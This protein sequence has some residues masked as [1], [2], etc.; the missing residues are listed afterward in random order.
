MPPKKPQNA[1]NKTNKRKGK[2]GKNRMA[3][4]VAS[5]VQR[6]NQKVNTAVKKE[7]QSKKQNKKLVSKIMRD[8]ASVQHTGSRGVGY[9][10]FKGLSETEAEKIKG[11]NL[12]REV[13]GLLGQFM[14]PYT[15][16]LIRVRTFVSGT[17]A[18]PTAITKNFVTFRYSLTDVLNKVKV[19]GVSTKQ[20]VIRVPAGT[21]KPLYPGLNVTNFGISVV[22]FYDPYVLG[23]LPYPNVSNVDLTDFSSKF[24]FGPL[25]S[26]NSSYSPD[27]FN[28]IP[29][30]GT[31]PSY[32]FPSSTSDSLISLNPSML[33]PAASTYGSPAQVEQPVSTFDQFQWF[34]IDAYPAAPDAGT[35]ITA[36]LVPTG[37]LAVNSI[38]LILIP[39]L[40]YDASDQ[41]Q[42]ASSAF[43]AVASGAQS[44]TSIDP[45]SSGWYRLQLRSLGANVGP[46]SSLKIRVDIN[47]KTSFVTKFVLNNSLT[48]TGVD[49]ISSMSAS[50]I[51]QVQLNGSSLLISNISMEGAKGGVVYAGV[52]HG[53]KTA[54][55]ALSRTADLMLDNTALVFQTPWSDGVYGFIKPTKPMTMR[56]FSSIVPKDTTTAFHSYV[57]EIDPEKNSTLAGMNSYYISPVIS[58]DQTVFSCSAN[59]SF[60]VAIEFQ[61]D[62]QLF[63]LAPPRVNNDAAVDAL[64]AMAL[65]THPFSSNPIHWKEMWAKLRSA[66]SYVFSETAPYALKATKAILP[67]LGPLGGVAAAGL[68][69]LG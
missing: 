47:Y 48:I 56:N 44:V 10:T 29:M 46:V 31:L 2:K 62:S 22:H 57:V 7:K 37:D 51:K 58:A 60:S 28:T 30:T 43:P 20:P 17:D 40:E 39:Q 13:K 67:T 21:T 55:V 11:R 24:T 64:E 41:E 54:G 26:S 16:P 6:L 59:F 69:L 33:F 45:G 32:Q 9:E 36:T 18:T 53:D 27:G 35:R 61:T 42:I 3:N 4:Q 23:A 52:S 38:A 49:N 50:V 12:S 25:F 14:L 63:A 1:L 34:W 15:S 68:E 19:P 65:I 5:A 66:A 8:Y